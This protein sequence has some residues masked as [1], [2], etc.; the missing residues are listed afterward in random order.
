[1]KNSRKKT[2][3]TICGLLLCGCFTIGFTIPTVYAAGVAT[4]NDAVALYDNSTAVGVNAS[5]QAE[6]S[7]AVGNGASVTGKSATAI[8]NGAN[9]KGDFAAAVGAGATASGLSSVAVGYGAQSTGN[10]S[11]ALMFG[12]TSGGYVAVASGYEASAGGD[13][14]IAMGYEANA[15]GKYAFAIGHQ[16]DASDLY[17]VAAGDNTIAAEGSVA[18]GSYV[19]AQ[20][21]YSVGVGY[22]ANPSGE[23]AVAVGTNSKAG[24]TAV[25]VGNNA[26]ATGD[27]SIAFGNGAKATAANS[28]AFGDSSEAAAENAASFLGGIVESTAKNSVAIGNGAKATL[29]DTVALGSGSV[30]G[31]TYGDTGAEYR[32]TNEG[33]AW[34][35]TKNAIAVGDGTK[36]T[37]QIIGVAAGSADTDAVNVA[38]L[39]AAMATV[40]YTA[41]EGIAIT[42]TDAQTISVDADEADF[43]YGSDGALELKKD[44]AVENYN[45]GVVTGGTV[46]DAIKDKADKATTLEGY[47]ITNGATKAELAAVVQDLTDVTARVGTNETN[48]DALS[49][50]MVALESSIDALS[51]RIDALESAVNVL[52]GSLES[53]IDALSDKIDTLESSIDALSDRLDIL[54]SSVES[55]A[56]SINTIN[57]TINAIESDVQTNKDNINTL[58]QKVTDSETAITN[59]ATD[60][61]SLIQRMETVE[62]AL[63]NAAYEAADKDAA[64]T[65][66]ANRVKQQINALPAATDVKT[67]DKDAIESARAAYDGLTHDQK[68]KVDDQTKKKLTDVENALKKVQDAANN[69]DIDQYKAE[70]NLEG[71]SD[72]AKTEV[73]AAIKE[74]LVPAELQQNYTDPVTR[75]QVAQL[76]VNLLEKAA[77]KTVDEIMDEKGVTINENAFADTTDKAVLAANALGIIK[78]TGDGKFSPNVTLKRAQIAAIINRVAKVMGVETEGY[79]HEFTD[80]TDNYEWADSELG[81]PVYADI[82]NGVGEGRFNPGGDLTIEQAIVITYRGLNALD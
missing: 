31:R 50:R 47:G 42:G 13:Y 71:V 36:V 7:T 63:E 1:M 20:G 56:E 45:L 30:A 12:A 18:F 37:R 67:A 26:Q 65:A 2:L 24:K 43:K 27:N 33:V 79:T 77:G 39:K 44:G 64:D 59:N 73:E 41:G 9:G 72:W 58:S 66:A 46:Y 22:A 17:S 21:L 76:F 49:D 40:S 32:G 70:P 23:G 52:L 82:I 14:S 54:E 53:S 48:I 69:A 28:I 11:L 16:A 34:I 81:W 62:E 60:I 5:A 61:S 25:A 29:E 4:G 35:S 57:T 68:A 15:A 55:N 38:Q 74:G 10:L 51:N 75:G 78:G 6:G 8:G 80:I 19:K 3:R